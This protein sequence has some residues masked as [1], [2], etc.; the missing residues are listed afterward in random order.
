M[1]RLKRYTK[2]KI[3]WVISAERTKW[4]SRNE[5]TVIDEKLLQ[6]NDQQSTAVNTV[7]ETINELEDGSKE[8]TQTE[9]QR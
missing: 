3:K 4:K 2:C 9:T 5:N 7:K 6:R 1:L 8:I